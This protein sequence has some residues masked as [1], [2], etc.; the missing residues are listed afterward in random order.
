M[1]DVKNIKDVTKEL[2][3]RKQGQQW[4]N[5]PK[6]NN[7]YQP[8]SGKSNNSKNEYGYRYLDRYRYQ[9]HPKNQYKNKNRQ[10]YGKR[11]KYNYRGEKDKEEK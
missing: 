1:K 6:N 11:P 5:K 8:Y 10:S 2:I 9:N 4:Y 3:N 7:R